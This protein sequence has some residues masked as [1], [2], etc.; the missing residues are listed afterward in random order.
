M[1]NKNKILIICILF[2]Q[3]GF[4]QIG[5]KATVSK[6]KLGVNER[7]KLSYI[8]DKQGADDFAAPR[9]I[10]FRVV[11]GPFQSSNFSMINGKT[12]FE[13]T[14]TYTLQPK[15][16]GKFTI[17]PATLTY[18]GK[19]VMSNPVKIV[20]T[21]AVKTPTNPNDPN[22][23]AQENI[24]LVVDF[25]NTNPYVGESIYVIYKLYV[26]RNKAGITNE[27]QSKPPNFNGFWNQNI[28]IKQLT[29]KRGTYQGKEMS[30]YII[31]KD[32]L[33]PQHAGNLKITP[34]QIDIDGVVATNQIDFFGRPRTK[35]INLT[36]TGGKRTINVKALPEEGKPSSFD[37]AVGNY[38]F[39]VKTNKTIVN[40]NESA[41]IKVKISGKGN[42]KLASLPKLEAP[43]GIEIYEPEHKENIQTTLNGQMGNV[44][45]IYTIVPQYK[46]KY[47]IPSLN[48]S[49][50]NPKEEKYYSINSQDIILNVPNG[51][52]LVTEN[53]TENNQN[54]TNTN[55]ANIHTKTSL[56][57]ISKKEDF[58]K[59]NLFYLLLILP[60][61][62]IPIGIY[63]GKKKRERAGDV[64]GNR[65][66]KASK[67]AKKYLSNAK[68]QL[69]NK[70]AFYI[71]LE[72]ALHNYLK[73]K[74]KV[75][76][77]DISSD[78][79]TELLKNKQIDDDLI[80]RFIKVLGDC[81]FARYAP[82]TN[83]QMEKDYKNAIEIIS[84][85]DQKLK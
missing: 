1:K 78:K 14:L 58:F 81:D 21:N 30:Y 16:K 55:F 66:R 77:T 56:H 41:L 49:Y 57:K 63:L 7:F 72:K 76:T 23:L 11:A 61:F 75:E 3:F 36:L 46:G 85:L 40:A 50:F 28:E 25:S 4:A 82:S 44:E 22:L 27:V 32:V 39:E 64:I 60:L 42:L 68:K 24:H 79:I 26:D 6:N 35:R 73:A 83:A 43:N 15:K 59:S 84:E 51:A 74:L 52:N 70:E 62:S 54:P 65:L 13:Q 20:V 71:A 53:T 48:F 47:K 67:L 12:S 37:G 34:I 2:L 5:F 18:K 33:I 31:R 8:I 38:N 29:E 80:T 69:G 10:N 17:T 19:T 45:E 9:F